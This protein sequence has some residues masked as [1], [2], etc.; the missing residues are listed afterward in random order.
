[1]IRFRFVL[2]PLATTVC[3]GLAAAQNPSVLLPTAGRV[4]RYPFQA[5]PYSNGSP[6]SRLAVEK[7]VRFPKASFL[8]IGFAAIH[9]SP[10]SRLEVVSLLDDEKEVWTGR[11]LK[12]GQSL[13]SAYFNGE[14]VLIRLW[15]A[16]GS[17]GDGFAIRD[18]A[19]GRPADQLGVLTL[20]GADNRL[21]ST[22]RRVARIIIKKGT[23]VTWCTSWL[24][25]PVNCFATA[26]HCL[27]G[28]TQVTAQFNVPKS[29]INGAL[30][31]PPVTDQ[32][33]WEG[34]TKRSYENNGVGRD[35]GVFTTQKNPV[36]KRYPGSVQRSYFLFQA[37][38]AFRT[39]LRVTGYGTDTT[40]N[41]TYNGIQQTSTGPLSVAPTLSYPGYHV[42]TT[43][44]NSGSP[45]MVASTNKA[46]GVHTHGGCSSTGNVYNKYN[47]GTWA[48]YGPFK[49]ARAKHCN[50]QPRPDFR[51]ITITS[52]SSTL[53]A[54]STY[55]FT[56]KIVNYGTATAPSAS[57]GFYISTNAFI[58]TA[59]LLIG[60]WSS[61]P[62]TV[63]SSHVKIL[64][65]TMPTTLKSGNCWLGVLADRTFA[66]TEE[67]ETNNTI[68]KPV[69][70]VGLPDL[71]VTYL[72]A[73]SS[74]TAGSSILVGSR[75]FNAGGGTASS[76]LTAIMLST[77]STITHADVFLG[78]YSTGI[79]ASG[80]SRFRTLSLR[81]PYVTNGGTHYLGAWADHS[82][83]VQEGNEANNILT[84]AISIANYSGA[85]RFVEFR[86]RWG[87]GALSTT[88]ASIDAS[89][90]GWAGMAVTAPHY[91]G[92]W[93]LLLWSANSTSFQIDAL[94][95][96]QLALLNTPIF[97]AW[98]GRTGTVTGK[99]YPSFRIPAG[100]SIS[101]SFNAYTYSAWFTPNLKSLIGFGSNHLRTW[102]VP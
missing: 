59:D 29:T 55:T 82:N 58:T 8:Q 94:T 4:E 45:V 41:R 75:T 30:V 42:D 60:A 23:S 35:W 49:L 18:V 3:L 101:S 26:G 50:L 90:G 9:L 13:E 88:V 53:K 72:S 96:F 93:Y 73:P 22:D 25:S 24:I 16:P 21:P 6:Q 20:C 85:G 79:L 64:V 33:P 2:V 81:I 83:T 89:V 19:V 12:A 44:G 56:T 76:S 68:S 71:R 87:T 34:T 57:H 97:A 67:D 66:V 28:A 80:S 98:F 31:N 47:K 65:A 69:V 27:S 11:S 7:L 1:M 99:A 48:D 86:P 54:R 17:R 32:Y 63:G 62:L 78:Q 39:T 36:T 5:G 92:Y 74:A 77:N 40:P 95:N 38:P 15:S 84:R 52:S 91:K 61:P 100:V 43:G 102:I 14:A 70:C 46:I 37:R 51:P 10:D